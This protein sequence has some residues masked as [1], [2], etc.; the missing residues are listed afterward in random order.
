MLVALFESM[1]CCN[2]ILHQ[3][4]RFSFHFSLKTVLAI[5]TS[6]LSYEAHTVTGKFSREIS[7]AYLERTQ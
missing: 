5:N 1:D 6:L 3:Y 4:D 2:A 7:H